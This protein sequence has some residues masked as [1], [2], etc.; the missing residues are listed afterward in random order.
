MPLSLQ[1]QGHPLSVVAEQR[2]ILRPAGRF[3]AFETALQESALAPF[4]SLGI[5]TLQLNLGKLCNQTCKHC[6][7]D[8]GP[9]RREVMSRE[10]MEACLRAL[11]ATEIPRVDLTGGAPELNPHFRWLVERVRELGRHVM[12]RCN[13]TILRTGGFQDL[14]AF[15]ARHRVEIVASL[16]YF[17]ARNTDA[18]RGEGVFE[19]SIAA[20]RQL[21]ELGYGHQESGLLLNLVY[22]PTG[23]FLPPR[24]ATAEPDF[25]RELLKRHDVVFNHLYVI[26]NMPINRFLEFLLRTEQYDAYM[27]RLVDAYNPAAAA[28]VMCRTTLSVGW[29]GRLFDCDFNQMLELPLAQ[30]QPQHIADFDPR[31][32]EIRRITTGLHCYG[33]TAGAGSSCTGEVAR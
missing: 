13:L 18:Q 5:D 33:C 9:D 3:R 19:A 8:A 28:D 17:L 16:P 1:G 4:Q 21:N 31:R 29:D 25:R 10:T 22:N 30:D 26:T 12:D 32:L 7:V 20:I 2:A 6:H 14:P 23:A 27:K 11:E 24:Q 15:L